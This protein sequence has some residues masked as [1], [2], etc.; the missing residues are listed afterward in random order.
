MHVYFLLLSAKLVGGISVVTGSECPLQIA[1]LA[2]NEYLTQSAFLRSQ[3]AKFS[4]KKCNLEIISTNSTFKELTRFEIDEGRRHKNSFAGIDVKILA[5]L[6]VLERIPQNS[7]F[8]WLD[9][10]VVVLNKLNFFLFKLRISQAD[11]SNL[12]S[13]TLKLN[14]SLSNELEYSK[15]F[16]SPT[17]VSYSL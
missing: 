12:D 1:T 16:D 15:L 8:L 5:V 7:I 14:K 4:G 2:T 10:S 9:S 13:Q 11:R 6:S 3:I 17:I